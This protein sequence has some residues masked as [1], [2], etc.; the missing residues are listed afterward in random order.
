MDRCHDQYQVVT[1]CPFEQYIVA[2]FSMSMKY[3]NRVANHR[4]DTVNAARVD[5]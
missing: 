4:T 1:L 5:S 2:G 3:L